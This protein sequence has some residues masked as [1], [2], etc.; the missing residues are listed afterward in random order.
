[1]YKGNNISINILAQLGIVL[2]NGSVKSHVKWQMRL[3]S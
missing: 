1:M 2:A 3:D